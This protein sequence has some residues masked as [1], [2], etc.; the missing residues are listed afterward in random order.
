MVLTS[1]PLLSF[2]F[3]FSHSSTP[4]G[5]PDLCVH[6][7]GIP[8]SHSIPEARE[9]ACVISYIHWRLSWALHG[10]R[11]AEMG[12]AC[13]MF[14]TRRLGENLFIKD[15]RPP[16]VLFSHLQIG[17]PL[18]LLPS[19]S[20]CPPILPHLPLLLLL[21]HK[22]QSPSYCLW[23]NHLFVQPAA[24]GFPCARPGKENSMTIS[25]TKGSKYLC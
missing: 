24:A 4:F 21:L 2:L 14:L 7:S 23:Q 9:A 11:I 17:F 22:R 10:E 12:A 19:S 13:E 20:S 8:G 1:A 18:S 15:Q 3:T 5:Y 25:H 16:W 6:P